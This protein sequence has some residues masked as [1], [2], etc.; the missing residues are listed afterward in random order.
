ML[1]AEHQHC[2]FQG[3]SATTNHVDI[4]GLE[5]LL[6]CI[7]KGRRIVVARDNDNMPTG[8]RCQRR[9]KIDPLSASV[10]EV[11]LTPLTVRLS[12]GVKNITRHQQ[13][14]NFILLNRLSQPG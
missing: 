3:F 8:I 2:V 11:K 10:A 4:K 7:E 6:G 12:A 14:I 1:I 13:G 9:L 5:Q